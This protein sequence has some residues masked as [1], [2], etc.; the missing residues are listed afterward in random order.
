MRNVVLSTILS[1]FML[2]SFAQS[3]SSRYVHTGLWRAMAT[4]S[5]RLNADEPDI[6]IHGNLEYY[7]DEEI[8]ARGDGYYHIG[9]FSETKRFDFKHSLFAGASY[10]FKTKS[11]FD[12]YLALQPGL[13]IAR[14]NYIVDCPVGFTPEQAAALNSYAE[15]NPLLS[16]VIG[17]NYYGERF[18]HFFGEIRYV[19]G[20]HF[21]PFPIIIPLNE[22][23]AS[24]G[25]G[26]NIN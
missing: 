13:S 6:Y 7:A 16:S 18:F 9:S 1:L 21:T 12:P 10:H 17:F 19:R 4:I 15:V 2:S 26:F 11:R 25:L 8:S 24:F 3:D 22:L 23:R 20:R 14:P 5:P